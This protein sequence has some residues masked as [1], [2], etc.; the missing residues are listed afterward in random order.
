MNE[1]T[2]EDI[3]RIVDAYAKRADIDKFSRRVYL[4]E[5]EKNNYNCNIP[6][7]VDTFEEEEEIS[8]A[9]IATE[10]SQQEKDIKTAQTEFL[11]QFA[12]LTA[13][14]EQT[15]AEISAFMKTLEGLF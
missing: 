14:D 13:S 8:L 7:Y 6:R 5:V 9:D 4:D 2:D 12:E 1:L 10:L 15:G 3:T 11:T